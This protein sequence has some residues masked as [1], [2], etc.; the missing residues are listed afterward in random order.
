MIVNVNQ[1]AVM[2][3]RHPA[4]L[5]KAR[6]RDQSDQSETVEKE[7]WNRRSFHSPQKRVGYDI[8]IEKPGMKKS[9]PLSD[10][11]V[12]SNIYQ[13]GLSVRV[14]SAKP[15]IDNKALCAC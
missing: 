3:V 10:K 12:P 6:R 15:D 7:R 8:A 1:T 14:P 9:S 5:P 2:D 11:Q 13:L 4:C